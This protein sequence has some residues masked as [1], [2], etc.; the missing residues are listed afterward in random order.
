[1]ILHPTDSKRYSVG[2]LMLM[3]ML[4]MMMMTLMLMMNQERDGDRLIIPSR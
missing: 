1:M 3:R 4:M 2:K